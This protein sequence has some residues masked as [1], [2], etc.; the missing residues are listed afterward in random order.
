MIFKNSK[1]YDILKFIALIVLPAAATLYSTVGNIW[2][3]PFPSEI[4]ATI[5]AI[6]TFMGAVLK[7]S[8]DKFKG[9]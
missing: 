6:D 5:M 3:F 2:G 4:A 7:V 1:V 9:A 8:S